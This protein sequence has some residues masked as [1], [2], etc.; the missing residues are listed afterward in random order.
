MFAGKRSI[1]MMRTACA[2]LA[3]VV[4]AGVGLSDD[5]TPG[6]AVKAQMVKGTIKSADPA[7]GV[8]VVNQELKKDG[9]TQI[10][11]RELSITDKVEFSITT[12]DGTEEFVG[13]AALQRLVDAKGSS[14]QVKCDKDVN[15][16]KVTVR[17]KQ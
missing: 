6:K 12:K 15:V 17:I 16:L 7:T 5:V 3:V 1:P 8:L 14:V 4:F 10:V 2:I 11:D 13:K 9:K